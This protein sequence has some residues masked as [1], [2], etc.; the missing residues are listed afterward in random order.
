MD[1]N[2]I[3]LAMC[4]AGGGVIGNYTYCSSVL[5]S[6]GTFMLNDNA[7]SYIEEK[8]KLEHVEEEKIK[9]ICDT[10]KVKKVIMELRRVHLLDESEFCNNI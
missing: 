8:N 1:K 6:V 4:N 3:R 2:E 9:M 5:Q 10:E 7:N